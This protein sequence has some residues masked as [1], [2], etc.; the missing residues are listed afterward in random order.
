MV[1]DVDLSLS[2]S[3]WDEVVNI[4]SYIKNHL[5]IVKIHVKTSYELIKGTKPDISY[6]HVCGCVCF[7]LNQKDQLSKFQE[8]ADKCIF[9]GY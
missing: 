4:S 2:L 8:K 1:V 7:I 5:I 6:F 9:L 3:L